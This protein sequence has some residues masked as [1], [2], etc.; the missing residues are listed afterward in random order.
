MA[1]SSAG[2]T[3][4]ALRLSM[5]MQ[6]ADPLIQATPRGLWGGAAVRPSSPSWKAWLGASLSA[7]P[8]VDAL[9]LRYLGA[10]GPATV[11]DAQPGRP[12][13]AGRSSTPAPSWRPYATRPARS[14]TCRRPPA[15]TRTRP[16]RYASSTTTTTCCS[17]T[18]TAAG[19]GM[20]NF[21]RVGLDDGR[22]ATELPAHRRHGRRHLAA[23]PDE[24][25]AV[26]DVR[27]FERVSARQL[28]E[29]ESE[30]AGL[31]D[32]WAPALTHEIRVER[33]TRQL[34]PRWSSYDGRWWVP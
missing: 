15:R 14:S 16:R 10:F 19:C 27:T 26:F 2:P 23:R 18:P 11:R 25:P 29:I 4:T 1:S 3:A 22:C 31:L 9:V 28:A 30:A 33:A 5:A 24:T 8:S 7:K 21:L 17:P 34:I 12:D 20:V 6:R 13:P 32:F